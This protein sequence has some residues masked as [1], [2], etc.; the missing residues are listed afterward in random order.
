MLPEVLMLVLETV[1][2]W[3]SVFLHASVLSAF[4]LPFVSIYH[5]DLGAMF[6]LQEDMRQQIRSLTTENEQKNLCQ[7]A[8]LVLF[9]VVVRLCHYL[10][11]DPVR[12]VGQGPFATGLL[13]K[14]RVEYTSCGAAHRLKILEPAT[15]LPLMMP[16]GSFM[17]PFGIIRSGWP[18]LPEIASIAETGGV[19][20]GWHGLPGSVSNAPSS[21]SEV[22]SGFTI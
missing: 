13:E 1:R 12:F 10:E 18:D 2:L 3:L 14:A 8:S 20:S 22:M 7:D 17:T 15:G 5:Q 9:R 16:V 19:G 11:E 21:F 6:D 4:L